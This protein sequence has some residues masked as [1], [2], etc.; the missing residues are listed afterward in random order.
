MIVML[1]TVILMMVIMM[2]VVVMMV[3]AVTMT[4]M[5]L[6]QLVLSSEPLCFWDCFCL[7]WKHRCPRGLS[8][9]LECLKLTFT[10]FLDWR[11]GVRQEWR[12][13]AV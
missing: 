4:M 6:M 10:S 2:V 3:T 9:A 11:E 5:V 1:M 13:L 7:N 8:S 12:L